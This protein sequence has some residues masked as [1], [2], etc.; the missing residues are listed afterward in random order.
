[1]Q[2]WSTYF[3][4]WQT[5]TKSN[6]LDWKIEMEQLAQYEG[7]MQVRSLEGLNFSC[8]PRNPDGYFCQCRKGEWGL[9]V[10]GKGWL[11]WDENSYMAAGYPKDKAE[12]LANTKGIH[13]SYK[14]YF[15]RSWN[16]PIIFAS[17]Q[18]LKLGYQQLLNPVEVVLNSYAYK[19]EGQTR[20]VDALEFEVS[21][22]EPVVAHCGKEEFKYFYLTTESKIR[23]G[24]ELERTLKHNG[25]PFER[26]SKGKLKRELTAAYKVAQAE[27]QK[28]TLKRKEI[29]SRIMR[30]QP[31]QIV[32]DAGYNVVS[33]GRVRHWNG[34][35]WEVVRRATK[36]DYK[37]LPYIYIY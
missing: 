11:A 4:N 20:M 15:A 26:V 37:T 7:K 23:L 12:Q 29:A 16:E 10:E 32:V 25:Y 24:E 17:Y 22:R 18:L 28:R 13:P 27:W 21:L 6:M 30:T 5:K 8:N 36:E 9:Y 3:T 35:R 1:M 14:V 33:N 34:K 19:K 2:S 31:P